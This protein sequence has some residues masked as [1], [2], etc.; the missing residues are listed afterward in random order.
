MERVPR[1]VR[2]RVGQFRSNFAARRPRLD[3]S[4]QKASVK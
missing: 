4:P 3:M 2:G 1:E